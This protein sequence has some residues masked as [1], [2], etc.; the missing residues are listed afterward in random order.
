MEL[1]CAQA[2]D[3][4]VATKTVHIAR[5]YMVVL[6]LPALSGRFI[7]PGVSPENEEERK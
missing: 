5:K 4:S 7:N 1:S 6:S 3:K 2:G